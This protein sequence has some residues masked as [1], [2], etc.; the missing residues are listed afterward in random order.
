MENFLS[1]RRAKI[2]DKLIPDAL[3]KGRILDMG[4]GSY[5]VFLVNIEFKEKYGI[6]RII[7]YDFS[8]NRKIFLKQFDL[9]ENNDFPF[10]DNFFSVVV[11]LAVFEHIKPER[12]L[13]ILKE[14]KRMLE[15]GGRL[16][17]TTPCGWTDKLLKIMARLKLVS[18]EEILEHKFLYN[19]NLIFQSLEKAGFK[20]IKPILATLNFFSTNGLS[21]KHNIL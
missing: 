9:E 5:P 15:P 20:K 18:S 21:R 6:D 17:L 13:A 3:R 10:E 1:K 7:N 2:A 4:C 8:A 12:L 11:A 16:I 19:R 14:I